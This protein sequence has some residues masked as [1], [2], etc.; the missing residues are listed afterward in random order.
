[1]NNPDGTLTKIMTLSAH[2]PGGHS[3]PGV[4]PPKS[5]A[6]G[7]TFDEYFTLSA[8][9][10]QRT[11]GEIEGGYRVDFSYSSPEGTGG[12]AITG[13]S[14]SSVLVKSLP[15]RKVAGADV[16]RPSAGQD[17]ADAS[18]ASGSDWVFVSNDGFVDLD[19]KITV[20]LQ[21]VATPCLLSLHL[22]G[23]ADLRDCRHKNGDAIFAKGTESAQDVVAKWREGFGE[24][25]YV[26]LVL[27]VTFDVPIY[28]TSSRQT[29]IY[30]ECR[31]LGH[32][33]LAGVGQ[34]TFN[35]NS[36]IRGVKLVV[37]K[38]SAGTHVAR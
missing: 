23:R 27:A 36:D 21:N 17:I 38:V 9:V 19:S 14:E 1:M 32:S 7:L 8:R 25:R 33:L 29:E 16:R 6:L 3:R 11:V 12:A 10:T 34:A 30:E 15:S 35:A 22:V 37:G 5:P 4:K 18:I 2:P 24:G 31:V 26:P 20:S 13:V 28:G